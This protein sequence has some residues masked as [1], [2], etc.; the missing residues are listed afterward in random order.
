MR[1]AFDAL[2]MARYG[3]ATVTRLQTVTVRVHGVGLVQKPEVPKMATGR[4]RHRP[5]PRRHARGVRLR[6]AELHVDSTCTIGD[7]PRP[8]RRADGP[9]LVDEGTSTTVFYSDQTLT[10]DDFGH[11]VIARRT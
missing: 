8:G 4:R 1:G 11:L 5:R 10:V 6:G 9:A 3:H 2:H 7:R